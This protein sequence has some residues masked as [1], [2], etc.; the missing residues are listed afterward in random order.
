MRI[1]FDGVADV[2]GTFGL[3]VAYMRTLSEGDAVHYIVGL[4]VNQFQF[5]MFLVTAHHFACSVV[6][7]MMGAEYGFLVVRAEGVELLQ[8]VVELRSDVPEVDLRID[9]YYGTGLFGEDMF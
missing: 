4:V 1:L 3:D 9:L 8:I 7:Y 5:D 6:V 2:E